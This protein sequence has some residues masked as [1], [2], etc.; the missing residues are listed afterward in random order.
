MN[1]FVYG[2]LWNVSSDCSF[3]LSREFVDIFVHVIYML[4]LPL[5]TEGLHCVSVMLVQSD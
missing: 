1:I 2:G 5:L 3:S 4:S